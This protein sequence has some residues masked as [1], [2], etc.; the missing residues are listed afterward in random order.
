M[1][2]LTVNAGSSSLKLRVIGVADAVLAT[3]DLPRQALESV[4]DVIG[5]FVLQ[6]PP[7]DAVGHRVVHGG[8]DFQGPLL[9][10]ARVEAALDRLADLAPLHNPPAIE[11]VKA[12]RRLQPDLPQVACFDTAFH[13]GLPAEAATYALPMEWNAR[14][15]LRRYGFHGLSHAYASRRAAELMGRPLGD[16]RLVTA[17]LGSGASLAAVAAG[18]SVDTTMGFTPLEGL[19]MGTRAGDLDPGLVLWLLRTGGLST[20]D[21]AE[22]LETRAGLLGLSCVSADLRL[23]LDAADAGDA[24]AGLAYG[25]Y[26]HRLRAGVAG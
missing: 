16:L 26:L 24:H 14:W 12:L 22:A 13:A 19:V 2:V 11:A 23:V 15:Q 7:P 21:V 6:G 9:V 17:H 20:D 1:R 8:H 18:R 3:A 5:Q 25:V 4:A 10:D